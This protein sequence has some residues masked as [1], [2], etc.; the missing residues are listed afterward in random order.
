LFLT[1]TIQ[2]NFIRVYKT[3]LEE[4]ESLHNHCKW[5][6]HLKEIPNI[7]KYVL[8]SIKITLIELIIEFKSIVYFG[9]LWFYHTFFLKRCLSGL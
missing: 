9:A 2:P 7:F 6:G 1:S 5:E 8:T 4:F 3:N